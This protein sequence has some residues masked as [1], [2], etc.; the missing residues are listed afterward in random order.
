MTTLS[1]LACKDFNDAVEELAKTVAFAKLA[2]A[3]TPVTYGQGEVVQVV[4]NVLEP[5]NSRTLT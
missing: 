5:D 1:K 4:L 3:G 2:A